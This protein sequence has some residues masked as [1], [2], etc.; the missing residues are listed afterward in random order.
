MTATRQDIVWRVSY[1]GY[2]IEKGREELVGIAHSDLVLSGFQEVSRRGL[3]SVWK[4]SARF[5][6]CVVMLSDVV[7]E[8]AGS[9]LMVEAT[10]IVAAV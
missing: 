3:N 10:S 2:W 4:E 9:D 5:C 1:V 8:Y 6:T 7:A